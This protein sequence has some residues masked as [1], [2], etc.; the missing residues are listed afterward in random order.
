L[1]EKLE[2]ALEQ[3][4]TE[5]KEDGHEIEIIKEERLS[6]EKC[7]QICAQLSDHIDEI[8]LKARNSET[9]SNLSDSENSAWKITDEGLE[10]CK[11]DIARTVVR[12][13]EF[14]KGQ[15]DRLMT[16]IKTTSGSEEDQAEI[17]RIRDEWE[18]TRQGLTVFSQ[19][20]ELLKNSVSQ[21][22][23]YGLGDSAQFMVSTN[24]QVLHGKNRGLGWRTRQVGGCMND[25]TVKQLS[26]DLMHVN[27]S[28]L[29]GNE[30]SPQGAGS[31]TSEDKSGNELD[32]KFKGHGKGF[33]LSSEPTSSPQPPSAAGP[34]R[35][36]KK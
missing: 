27:I 14:E 34:S 30:S 16:K 22:E 32:P 23:N 5:N 28:G 35:P 17:A 26:R 33:K 21:I 9:A 10:D 11:N 12:L 20:R 7:L 31:S 25:D 36:L 2:R 15:F 8:Q 4:T 24:G 3:S 13:E 29:E 19:A 18:A 6:T 1:D